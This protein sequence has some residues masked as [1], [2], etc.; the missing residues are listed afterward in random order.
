MAPTV[1]DRSIR[2]GFVGLGN[3]GE[4][5]ALALLRDGWRLSVLDAVAERTEP[6]VRAGA[7]LGAGADRVRRGR[8]C[9][10]G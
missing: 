5:M 3:L 7:Q 4:S 1:I 10:A 9:R 6:C 8:P 2:I